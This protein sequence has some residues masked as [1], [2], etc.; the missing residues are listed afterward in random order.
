MTNGAGVVTSVGAVGMRMRV[1]VR[2]ALM[3]MERLE[4]TFLVAASFGT[5]ELGVL[6]VDI[7]KVHVHVGAGLAVSG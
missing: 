6:A 5:E 1:V 4:S 3:V 7:V 2:V